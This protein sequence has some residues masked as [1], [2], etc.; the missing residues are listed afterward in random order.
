ME[1]VRVRTVAAIPLIL[2]VTIKNRMTKLSLTTFAIA[3]QRL[4]I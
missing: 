4:V 1:N 2:T 3:I